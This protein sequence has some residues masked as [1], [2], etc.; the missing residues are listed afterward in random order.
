M[1]TQFNRKDIVSFGNYIFKE[2]LKSNRDK[3]SGRGF[4]VT[5]ADVENWKESISKE[6]SRV[7]ISHPIK[8]KDFEGE[9]YYL[10]IEDNDGVTHYFHKE[11]TT[12]IDG[13]QVHFREGEYDGHSRKIN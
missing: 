12:K 13:K 8:V 4:E 11:H 6:S 9:N 5:H 2:A 3:E 1:V 10:I 7:L